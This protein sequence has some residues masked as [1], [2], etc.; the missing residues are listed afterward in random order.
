[1]TAA[2]RAATLAVLVLLA[3]LLIQCSFALVQLQENE[4]IIADVI[5]RQDGN[6]IRTTADLTA[7]LNNNLSGFRRDVNDRLNDSNSI[8]YARS[9]QAIAIAGVAA[10]NASRRFDQNLTNA[11]EMA[12]GQLHEFNRNVGRVADATAPIKS[13]V[14]QIDNAAP[15]WLDCE[16]NSSCA[17]NLFQ[18]TAKAVQNT[19]SELPSIAHNIDVITNDFSKLTTNWT[20]PRTKAQRFVDIFGTGLLFGARVYAGSR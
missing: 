8:L 5:Q 6:L 19:A 20:K 14:E 11:T 13:L 16:G 17:Y 3:A 18:G 4:N 7:I 1:M 2:I 10:D 15:L 12:R 9:G